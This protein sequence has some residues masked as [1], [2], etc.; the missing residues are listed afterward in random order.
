[1]KN[2]YEVDRHS[3]KDI[4]ADGLTHA[5]ALRQK[6]QRLNQDGESSIAA[7][8]GGAAGT[9]A[10]GG[11]PPDHGGHWP[12]GGGICSVL[13]RPWR[14]SPFSKCGRYLIQMPTCSELLHQENP[15]PKAQYAQPTATSKQGGRLAQLSGELMPSGL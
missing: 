7:E 11:A 15:T 2:R 13:W 6:T 5:K 14:S 1:M 3:G 10:Q 9:R 8:A 4:R 12:L